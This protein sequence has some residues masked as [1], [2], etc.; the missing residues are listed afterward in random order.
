VYGEQVLMAPRAQG[1][2]LFGWA[3]PFIALGGGAVACAVLLRSW[4]R[5]PQV[6]PALASS[7]SG[8]GDATPDE[9]ARL[10]ARVRNDQ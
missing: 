6:A 7:P 5:K 1:F 2:N 8:R 4:R 9:L 10:D 3:A